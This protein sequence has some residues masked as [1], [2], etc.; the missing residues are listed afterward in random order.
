MI[1]GSDRAL[2][3]GFIPDSDCAP[4]VAA[5]ES[6]LFEKYDLHVELHRETRWA[7]IRDKIINGDLDAAHAPASL[8]FVVNLGI[9][10]DQCACVAGLVLS[11]QGNSMTISQELWHEGV[12]DASTLR[13]LVYRNWGRRTY[14]FG[15][16]F[17]HSP[18]YFLLRQ[19][20]KGG[21]ILPH[22][23]VRLVVMP[24]AQM[25]PTLKLGYIDGYCV[26]EPWT[27][28][29]AESEAGVAL[30]TSADLAPLH[31][32]KVLMVRSD[33]ARERA[34]E[35]ERLIAALIE[36]C[37]FCDK[38]GN[39]PLLVDM[40]SQ[41][42]YVNAPKDCLKRAFPGNPVDDPA[43]PVGPSIFHHNL[44]NAPTNAKAA[45]LVNR[46]YELMEQ[47]VLPAPTSGRAPVLKNIFRL[48]IFERAK[49]VVAE[50]ALAIKAELES[51][52]A[53]AVRPA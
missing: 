36:A 41:P 17:P 35:H 49:A 32:E 3:V 52:K 28:L 21:G 1:L 5:H 53:N 43:G 25:F 19:W 2:H 18:P 44:A 27:S 42:Q 51:Y 20:L 4:I 48:D 16:E 38:P 29:A 26:G 39:H 47:S 14:S 7:N 37:A 46:L 11:L 6:G 33:F 34:D 15:V 9:D 45:W 13:D 22:T 23:E 30:A 40:L 12:R 24:P 31:P 10:S 8:P 50:Q